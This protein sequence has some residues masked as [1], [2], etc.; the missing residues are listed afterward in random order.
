M[1]N[2]LILC[3]LICVSKF[4]FSKPIKELKSL[5]DLPFED[6]SS[7][8]LVVWDVHYTI[9]Q[10]KPSE[11]WYGSYVKFQ[12][13][14]GSTYL[15]VWKQK[16]F[17]EQALNY[18][19]LSFDLML[20]DSKILN[21]FDEINSNGATQ[22]ALTA[23]GSGQLGDFKDRSDRTAEQLLSVGI[24]L[25]HTFKKIAVSDKNAKLVNSIYFLNNTKGKNDFVNEIISSKKFSR[26]ILI[27]DQFD[28]LNKILE[29]AEKDDRTPLVPYLLTHKNNQ[30]TNLSWEEMRKS[31]QNYD[32]KVK[33]TFSK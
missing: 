8:D 22:I 3:I 14:L 26:V 9:V 11:M 33:S 23:I 6:F 20:T 15:K 25:D 16:G 13:Y 12:N 10:P 32:L 24:S 4:A 2:K 30:V 31:W 1:K 18:L 27:E 19:L 21:I 7:G 17:L 28:V 5:K 29:E